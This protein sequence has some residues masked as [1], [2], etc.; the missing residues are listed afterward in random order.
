MHSSGVQCECMNVI[1]C[2]SDSC[3]VG[4]TLQCRGRTGKSQDILLLYFMSFEGDE[5]DGK[6]SL[7]GCRTMCVLLCMMLSRLA[8]V[9]HL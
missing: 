6:Y 9:T 3:N 8:H 5:L 2:V 1:C 7:I 4:H